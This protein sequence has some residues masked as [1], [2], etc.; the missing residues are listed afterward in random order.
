M[1]KVVFFVVLLMA[2]GTAFAANVYVDLNAVGANTGTSWID[3]YTNLQSAL[4][5]TSGDT[6][7]VAQGTY[8]PAAAGGSAAATFAPGTPKLSGSQMDPYR[9]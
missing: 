4:P 9:A 7:F 6:I 8:T 5:G 3:A 2:A 1:S